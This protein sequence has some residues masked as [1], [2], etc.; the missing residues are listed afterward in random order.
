M[1]CAACDHTNRAGRKFC[2]EC[3]TALAL[4]CPKCGAPYEAGE[5][6]CGE[7]GAA[8]A[9]SAASGEPQAREVDRRRPVEAAGARKIVTI[10]FADLVGST[11]LHERL[12]PESAGVFIETYYRA[13]RA[14]V[15]AH[16]GTVT[17][18]LGDGVMAVFG[19]PRVSED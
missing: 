12:D 15:E 13:M 1:R 7:C 8:T 2:A 16:G 11:A 17:Q 14:A 6:F 9:P 4:A 3:G 19:V 10:V 18:L 5:K